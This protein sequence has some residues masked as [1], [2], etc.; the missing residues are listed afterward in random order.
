MALD[1][2]LNKFTTTSQKVVTY[3]WVDIQDGTGI[4][5]FA[6]ARAAVDA[7]PANDLHI[8]LKDA[9]TTNGLFTLINSGTPS[10]TEIDF[11]ISFNTPR[12]IEGSCYITT[13]ILLIG[14]GSV[15]PKITIIKYSN[16]TETTLV[17]QVTLPTVAG[18]TNTFGENVTTFDIPLTNFAVGDVFRVKYN[19]NSATDAGIDLNKIYHY[20]NGGTATFPQTGGRQSVLLPFRITS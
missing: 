9:T 7:T 3:D 2:K 5:D 1:P 12:L 18:G 20:P 11:D 10:S 13:P 8:L 16:A 4:I 15:T 6:G 19:F 17:A 14:N